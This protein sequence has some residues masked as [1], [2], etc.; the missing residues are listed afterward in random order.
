VRRCAPSAHTQ[1]L[2][3][4]VRVRICRM[5][6]SMQSAVREVMKPMR[7]RLLHAATASGSSG[8]A[9]RRRSAPPLLRIREEWVYGLMLLLV[10]VKLLVWVEV[11]ML[12][13]VV[14]V[15]C[16]VVVRMREV[17]GRFRL[18]VLLQLLLHLIRV[19]KLRM[20]TYPPP[21]S[22]STPSTARRRP[23]APVPPLH[24]TLHARVLLHYLVLLHLLHLCRVQGSGLGFR[25]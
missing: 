1:R 14:V 3:A 23:S 25:V 2:E 15:L 13:L 4:R 21:S 12:M 11:L 8:D 17:R 10:L 16:L 7:R 24:L 19:Q 20:P 22:S 18:P 6:R 5:C 9:L